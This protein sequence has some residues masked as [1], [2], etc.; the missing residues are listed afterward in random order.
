MEMKP[1]NPENLLPPLDDLPE[2]PTVD[3]VRRALAA[4]SARAHLAFLQA[5]PCLDRDEVIRRTGMPTHAASPAHA[6][7]DAWK[8]QR[9]IFVVQQNGYE[10]Y[11]A[12][13]FQSGG[14]P[15]PNIKKILAALPAHRTPWQVALWFVSPNGWLDGDTPAERLDDLPAVLT[16]AQREAEDI[17]G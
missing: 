6:A 14:S 2:N 1:F 11:P 4:D 3:Q 16:A 17:E 8:R 9:R 7:L 15:H 5:V 10:H 12:F 13:Q